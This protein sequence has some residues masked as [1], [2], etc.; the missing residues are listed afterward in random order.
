MLIAAILLHACASPQRRHASEAPAP[1]RLAPYAAALEGGDPASGLEVILN[2][3]NAHCLECHTHGGVGGPFAPDLAIM[4]GTRDRRYLLAALVDPAAD[5]AVGF[6]LTNLTLRDGRSVAGMI[7]RED[8]GLITLRPLG[9][10]QV[11]TIN[12]ADVAA[13]TAPIS[14][15]PPMGGV[16]TIEQLRDITAYLARRP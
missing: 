15:M 9:S 14:I 11:L 2:N 10:T 1:D 6:A 13:R 4:R 16:L 12:A 5:L 8:A 3:P 7:Q